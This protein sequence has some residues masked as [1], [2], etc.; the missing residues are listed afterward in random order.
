ME[1]TVLEPA[2][3]RFQGR[4]RMEPQGYI[5]DMMDVKI[6][7][8]FALSRTLWPADLQQLYEICYQDDLLSYFDLREALHQMEESGHIERKDSGGEEYYTIT[9]KGRDAGAVLEDSLAWPVARRVEKAAEHFNVEMRRSS[10]IHTETAAREGGDFAVRLGLDYDA[11]SLMK[12]EL[13]APTEAQA[14]KLARAFHR[15]AEDVY[16]TVM[17]L[18][19]NEIE[20][21]R[22]REEDW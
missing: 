15:R 17:N 21:P 22:R 2:C 20:G 7:I 1:K 10:L 18:L 5:H 4:D 13:M 9:Q 11:G 8:L 14:R 16:N 19:L 12:L 3:V 6:L